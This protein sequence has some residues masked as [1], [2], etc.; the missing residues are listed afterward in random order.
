MALREIKKNNLSLSH[1]VAFEKG[2]IE[3]DNE[4]HQVQ[5]QW[6]LQ[7]QVQVSG[8]TTS[9]RSIVSTSEFVSGH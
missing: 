3:K 1:R 8:S 9:A 5:S 2:Y 6:Q 4:K 7:I